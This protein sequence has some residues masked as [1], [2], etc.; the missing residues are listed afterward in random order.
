MTAQRTVKS[1]ATGLTVAALLTTTAG[2]NGKP[3]A[4]KANTVTAPTTG[5][6]S[7]ATPSASLTA[8]PSPAPTVPAGP[9]WADYLPVR[10]GRTCTYGS[11]SSGSSFTVTSTLTQ[12]YSHVMA[13]TDGT[14]FDL[15]Y[16]TVTSATGQPTSRTAPTVLPYRLASDGTLQTRPGSVSRYGFR[17]TFTGFEVYPTISELR[18]GKHRSSTITLNIS[19]TTAATQQSLTP[20]LLPGQRVLKAALTL[21]VGPAS[22]RASIKTGQGVYSDVVGVSFKGLKLNV[23]NATAA[24]K[25]QFASLSSLLSTIGSGIVYLAKGVGF[26]DTL[27]LGTHVP[28]RRCA[29]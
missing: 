2:C 18:A 4:A 9:S 21:D 25:Q 14:T 22:R 1:L 20:S 17:Y 6:T 8:S 16:S 13:T 11:T 5:Q 23:L 7:D 28:L 12:K 19:G 29:G 26:V 15:T 24:G 10:N 3:S 27:T